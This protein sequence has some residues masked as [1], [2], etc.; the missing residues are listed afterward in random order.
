LGVVVPI[1]GIGAIVVPGFPAPL[2]PN[3][4]AVAPLIAAAAGQEHVVLLRDGSRDPAPAIQS[5]PASVAANGGGRAELR[6]GVTSTI[7]VRYQWSHNG[8]PLPGATTASLTLRN[9]MPTQAGTYTVVATSQFGS[10]TSAPATV[11]VFPLATVVADSPVR[12]SVRLGGSFQLGV[13]VASPDAAGIQWRHNGLAIPGATTATYTVAQATR[14]D[15]GWYE[16][17]VVN[18]AGPAYSPPRFVLVALDQA[19]L[20]A[21]GD[22]ASLGLPATLTGVADA[23]YSR[24]MGAHILRADGTVTAFG[25][26]AIPALANVVQLVGSA[27]QRAALQSDGTV[28]TWQWLPGTPARVVDQRAVR[29]AIFSQRLAIIRADGSAVIHDLSS[30][31]GLRGGQ[32]GGVGDRPGPDPPP[33]WGVGNGG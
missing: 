9:V 20:V 18:A 5:Q 7:P 14:A 25:G 32:P 22:A 3:G 19:D 26:S 24:L 1:G 2:L 30:G 13:T 6:V 10:V 4:I 11:T 27:D 33:Q 15:A 8:V 31:R 28:T 16:A 12:Q 23:V 21:W 29:I 17:E